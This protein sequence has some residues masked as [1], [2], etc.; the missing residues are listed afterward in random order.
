MRE[1]PNIFI[2]LLNVLIFGC[3][4]HK[5]TTENYDL[6]SDSTLRNQLV[7]IVDNSNRQFLKV[8]LFEAL[9]DNDTTRINDLINSELEKKLDWD[10]LTTEKSKR[11]QQGFTLKNTD[12]N[13]ETIRL[14]ISQSYT[15]VITIID[16]THQIDLNIY[17]I[18]KDFYQT[19]HLE[20]RKIDLKK[21]SGTESIE[22]TFKEWEGII[23]K[24]QLAEYWNLADMNK[25][26]LDDIHPTFWTIESLTR[27]L[28]ESENK[29]H[30]ISITNPRGCFL[31]AGKYIMK[32]SGE[33]FNK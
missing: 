15:G 24:L 30:I 29:H 23:R 5:P 8:E 3:D 20:N 32:L 19:I 6:I 11:I 21:T 25:S 13:L 4:S 1:L 16:V 12:P 17:S 33:N 2:I 28:S 14:I 10:S 18:Q 27:H 7:E 26:N 9:I 22:I 31:D